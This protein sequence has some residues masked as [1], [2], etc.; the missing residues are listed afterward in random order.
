MNKN[1]ILTN[2]DRFQERLLDIN[3]GE[4]VRVLFNMLMETLG[5]DEKVTKGGVFEAIKEAMTKEQ[6]ALMEVSPAMQRAM[7]K[8]ARKPK[9]EGLTADGNRLTMEER[10]YYRKEGI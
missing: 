1:D 9:K 10:T 5:V 7:K 6:E 3:K 4:R 2:K 8:T